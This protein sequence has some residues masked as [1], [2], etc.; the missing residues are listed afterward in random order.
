MQISRLVNAMHFPA[1][2]SEAVYVEMA[3]SLKTGPF[4][5]RDWLGPP[6][7]SLSSLMDMMVIQMKRPRGQSSAM[8]QHILELGRRAPRRVREKKATGLGLISA[9]AGLG[10]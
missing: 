4:L 10:G 9:V 6:A 7:G 3:F 5:E 8:T 1:L 2:C